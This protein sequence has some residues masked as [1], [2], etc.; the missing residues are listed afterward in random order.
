[1]DQHPSLG[2]ILQKL[3]TVGGSDLHLKVGS[4]PAYR[5]DG[6]L[7]PAELAPLTPD[8]TASLLDELLPARLKGRVEDLTDIDFAYGQS[9]LG[10]FRVTAYRQ[11]GSINIVVRSVSVTPDDLGDLGLPSAVTKVCEESHGLI[12]VTGPT[13]SGKTTTCAAMI[14]HINGS[15]GASIVTVEDP[16]EVLHRDRR[17]IVSQ[18]EVGVDTPSFGDGLMSALRQDPDVIYVSELRDRATIEAALIA[19]ETGHLVISTMYTLDAVETVHR[20]LDSFPADLERRTRQMLGISLRAIVS[21]R[22]IP[23]IDGRGR[24]VVAEILV[25]NESV[26][27]ELVDPDRTGDLYETMAEGA[28]YGMRTMDQAVIE[29]FEAGEISFDDGLAHVVAPRDFK[30]AAGMGRTAAM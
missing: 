6:V 2:E 10:R 18:R 9:G 12:I 7:H 14:D 13:G 20:I 19:A 26:G 8:D 11:R 16:I 1:M 27:E 28:F 25:N 3:G 29:R 15:R 23:K 17:S 4:P 22:L 21:Q 5:I 24:T 30:I